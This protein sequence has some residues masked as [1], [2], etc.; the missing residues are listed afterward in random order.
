MLRP[1]SRTLQTFLAVLLTTTLS[2]IFGVPTA[3]AI[4][5]APAPAEP[6]G[7]S[8]FLPG[9]ESVFIQRTSAFPG[10]GNVKV[11]VQLTAN[12]V[13]GLFKET[14]H[15]D[16][17]TIGPDGSQTVLRDDGVQPDDVAGD[18]LFTGLA[19]VDEAE[20]Q[21]RSNTDTSRANSV[22]S[23][24]VFA[25]R[26]LIGSEAPE[27]FDQNAFDAGQVVELTDPVE[28][29]AS[30]EVATETTAKSVTGDPGMVRSH[31]SA[32]VV[33]GINAFQNQVLMIT[34]LSVVQD[35]ARTVDPC[36]GA[37][38]PNGPWTFKHLMTEMAN[39]AASGINPSTF[40]ERWLQHWL[41]PQTINSDNV[42]ARPQMASL[43]NQWRTAS[44]GGDLDLSIAPFR[45][46]AIVSRLD[47]ATTRGGGSGYAARGGDFLDAGEARFVFGVVL[48]PGYV[49]DGFFN[50][51]P[52]G[53]GCRSLPFTVIFEFRVPKCNCIGVR[54]WARQWVHLASL[55]FPSAAYNKALEKITRQFASAN[56]NP[57]KPNGSALGQLRT[58]EIA[59]TPPGQ[60]L[61]ELR[62][63]QLDQL[64]FTFLTEKTVTDNPIQTLN[65]TITFRDWVLG[66]ILTEITLHGI[67]A[68]LPKVPLF[69]GTPLAEFLGGHA[70]V[71]TG[72]W[73]APG[74]NFADLNENWSRHRAS[75]NTCE[76]CHR[77]ET[78]TLFV[79]VE[80][81][82]PLPAA[83][84]GFL[85]GIN[86]VPDPAN[87]AGTPARDFDDLAR[88]E[89]D[90]KKKAR[91]L[92][93]RFHPI[94]LSAVLSSLETERRLPAD[95]FE[96]LE[97]LPLEQ[98]ISV[99][100]DAL[101][102]TPI[103]EVH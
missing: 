50:A 45:L 64:P 11:M 82:A 42:P 78:Q 94:A 52:L 28:T 23:V 66:P 57:L 61:W 59:L 37:G 70:P 15:S 62:E 83:L 44:G 4:E 16:F 20:L 96:G 18:R 24:P 13:N 100:E 97:P 6:E 39:P 41:V 67:D 99:A 85:T 5:A 93:F 76:G 30:N 31:A 63:F 90:I 34:D 81:N 91:M 49:N 27:P 58:N 9:P 54:S 10:L 56:S 7:L 84:S 77:F 21:E 8:S 43:I 89:L 80:P 32:A 72:F 86:G 25:G 74:I 48:P 87:P 12:D 79:H 47:L 29:V 33:P 95:P 2:S 38:N 60:F 98:Q 73:N 71:V 92:C 68:P 26:T 36:T 55:P 19:T 102:G 46:L 17:L 75:L 51:M 53:G 14:G 3:S 101:L 35:P 88:R 103:T 65:N 1:P 22:Q 69:F 40:V